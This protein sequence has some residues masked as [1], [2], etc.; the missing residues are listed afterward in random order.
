MNAGSWRALVVHD[1]WYSAPVALAPIRTSTPAESA[2]PKPLSAPF[3]VCA[4]GDVTLGTN[5]DPEWARSAA[6]TLWRSFGIRPDPDSIAPSLKPFLA[7]ADLVLLN[8]EGAIGVGSG[9]AQMRPEIDEL[10][11]VSTAAE[12]RRGA[13]S[14]GRQHRRHRRQR[15]EQ[16]RARRRTRRARYDRSATRRRRH[17]RHRRR[18]ARDAPL[19]S[20]RATRSACSGSTPTARHRTLATFAPFAGTSPAPPSSLASSSSRC[21]SARKVPRAQRTRNATER[22]LTKINRGNPVGFADAAFAG[23]ATLV[24][25]HGPHVLA[26]RR[27]AR[28]PARALLARQPA[29]VRSVQASRTDESRRRRLRDDRFGALGVARRAAPDDAGVA[30]ACSS[31]IRRTAPGR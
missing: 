22:F 15:R 10:L 20:P 25:G 19:P 14:P 6:D 31:R 23:G 27:M 13:P 4:G 24:V 5:L 11:C 21:I 16:S 30:R 26:R 8:V 29:D 12:R 28:R 7:G 18:H 2:K 1:F 3:R 17:S 9:A